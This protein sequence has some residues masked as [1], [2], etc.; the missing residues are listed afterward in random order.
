MLAHPFI[1]GV[2]LAI[3]LLFSQAPEFMQ[4][5]VQR[6]GGAIDELARIVRHFDEDAGRSGY[7]RQGALRIMGSNSERLVRDQG[8]RMEDNIAR[9][10]RLRAQQEAL[11]D[12]GSF[13]RFVDFAANVDGPLFRRTVEDYAPALPLTLQGAVA[14]IG[15]FFATFYAMLLGS[16]WRK[17]SGRVASAP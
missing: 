7:D 12:G 6:L 16:H 4:Q 17:R 5:Y 3:G 10:A 13:R 2:S 15:G 9:L 14:A 11:R 8:A 1:L